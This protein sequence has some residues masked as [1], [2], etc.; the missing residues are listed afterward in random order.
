MEGIDWRNSG[1]TLGNHNQMGN[2][3]HKTKKTQDDSIPELRPERRK[4]EA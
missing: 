2:A 1:E 4:K 3:L